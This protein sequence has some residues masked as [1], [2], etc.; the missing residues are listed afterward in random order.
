MKSRGRLSNSFPFT[1]IS[2]Y[3]NCGERLECKD[4]FFH[5]KPSYITVLLLKDEWNNVP[6]I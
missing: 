3:E 2:K 5:I 4:F 6:L 1:S